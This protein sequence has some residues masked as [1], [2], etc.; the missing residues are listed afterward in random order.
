VA[1]T[2]T[3]EARLRSSR[4][5]GKVLK[6]LVG[7]SMLSHIIERVGRSQW[8][9]RIVV[10]TTIREEDSAVAAEAAH[11]GAMSFRGSERDILSRL[12]GALRLAA[13]DGSPP[14]IHVSLTGDNPFIDP[15]LIDDMVETML[16][17][18]HDYV[19]TTHMRHASH[20]D[21]D[22]T[23]PTG[24]SVQVVRASLVH[25]MA[26]EIS[27]SKLREMGL[28]CVYNNK[29]GRFKRFAFPATGKYEKW[30]HPELR[31]TVDTEEDFRVAQKIYGALYREDI[32]FS[33]L[34]A[35]ELLLDDPS[36]REINDATKQRE[37]F[38]ALGDTNSD[39]LTKN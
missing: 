27:D 10:A 16:E 18:G 37:G 36:L 25:E 9:D 7:K 11:C 31:M 1:V 28:Y 14:D 6:P 12:A 19:A 35:I 17:G 32:Q 39:K 34:R 20:W 23:F 30:R 22:R 2:A 3:L 5:P 4:L 26:T 21:E 13:T 33:T 15:E 8:I 24:V 29:N 38:E